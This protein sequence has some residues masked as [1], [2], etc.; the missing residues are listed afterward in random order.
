MYESDGIIKYLSEKY[1][2]F[3][4]MP[5][6]ASIYQILLWITGYRQSHH[7]CHRLLISVE[8]IPFFSVWL[9]LFR[10][11]NSSFKSVTWCFNG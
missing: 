1:G 4:L 10:R 3:L 9:N 6:S 7:L 11:W 5:D 8:L 2:R